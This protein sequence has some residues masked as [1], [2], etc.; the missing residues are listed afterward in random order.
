MALTRTLVQMREGVRKFA[1]VQGATALQRHPDADLND[2]VNRALGSLHRK[3]T[4]AV[5]DQ[6]F[7]ATS[8]TTTV[9]G[10]STY[11]LPATFESLLLVELTAQGVKRWL[12]AYE[13]HEHAALTDPSLSYAGV[14]VAYRLAAG[15]IELLP[16]PTDAYTLLIWYLPASSNLTADS[17][18]YDTINRLDDYVYAY[19]GRLVAIKDKNWDLVSASKGI[20]DEMTAEIL[21]LGRNRDRNSP[22]RIVDE[23]MA[24]R[25]GRR[26]GP[27]RYR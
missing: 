1:N 18:T 25:W 21:A 14:P 15:N 20:I 7:L 3:L 16:T 23:T 10:T 24:D 22:S 2:Y 26:L 9:D 12:T 6:R 27:R 11:A 13:P 19:A 4:E 8:S 17:S 5:P